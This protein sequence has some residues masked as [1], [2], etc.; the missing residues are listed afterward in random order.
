MKYNNVEL[1]PC[2]VL[3]QKAYRDT[4]ALLEVFSRQYGRIGL[5]ARGIK[6]SKSKIK[7][8]LQPFVPLLLSWGGKGD[9][10]TLKTA[11]ANGLAM[12]LPH[13]WV[14]SGF[15]LNELLIRLTIRHDPH[16]DLYG[17]YECTLKLLCHLAHCEQKDEVQSEHQRTLR[18]FE[19][20]LL[21]DLGYGLMLDHD[22]ESDIPIEKEEYYQ[23]YPEKG[24]VLITDRNAKSTN[25]GVSVKGASLLS[26]AQDKLDDAESLQEIKRLMRA[27]LSC[28]LGTKP[29]YS[30]E[31]FRVGMQQPNRQTTQRAVPPKTEQ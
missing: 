27:V 24:P 18:L 14:M 31:M 7:G 22:A 11:E 23:Y 21:A 29:L 19:K 4:S 5:V 3:H 16:A 30:R 25:G 20:H 28:Y 12:T 17:Q 15:Y 9:L 6:S 13:R 26:L 8:L 2:Y 1:A 10:Q